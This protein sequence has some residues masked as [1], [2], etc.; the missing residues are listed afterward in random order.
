LNIGGRTTVPEGFGIGGRAIGGR[1]TALEGGGGIGGMARFGAP[2]G[3]DGGPLLG[4]RGGRLMRT[5]SLEPDWASPGFAAGVGGSVMRT[6]SFF[7]SF[8]SLMPWLTLS[9]NC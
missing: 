6:V 8:R 5:V 4:G 3:G 7:G 2:G 1:V 9:E